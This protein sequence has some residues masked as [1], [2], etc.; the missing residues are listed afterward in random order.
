MG[1]TSVLAVTAGIMFFIAGASYFHIIGMGAAALAGV[2]FLIKTAPYRM[3]RFM[4]FL[5]PSA[6]AKGTGYHIN[7]ALLAVGSGGLFGLGFGRSRQKFNYLPE[8][9]TDSIFA[10]IAEELGMIRASL[11]IILFILFAIRGYR[12]ANNAPDTFSRLVAIGITTW[13]VS[14]AFINIMAILS[15]IPLTGVPL[16]FISLGGSSLMTLMFACGILLNISKHAKE[17]E[18]NANRRIGRG[19]WWSY[20]TGLGSS[21]GA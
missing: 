18:R 10:V 16:P 20:L 9:S 13:I 1:T 14:Q 3:A 5:N 4:I 2:W 21:I 15:M 8:A 6:D 12:I 11:L 17:G 19:N 7:Q